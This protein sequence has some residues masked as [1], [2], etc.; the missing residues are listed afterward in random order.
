VDLWARLPWRVLA[1]RR[2]PG[3]SIVDSTVGAAELLRAVT[4]G[5]GRLPPLRD[6]DWRWPLPPD[7]GTAVETL[8]VEEVRR[9]G[10]A[11][12]ETL[13]AARGRVPERALRDALL[14][15]VPI[16][17]S[18]GGREIPVRQ[19]LVQA[20]LRMG[21]DGTGNDDE[22]TVRIAGSWVALAAGTSSVWLQN[23][24][25]LTIRMAK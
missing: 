11:A 13:R 22:M 3:P 14:E 23:A 21:F 10:L 12:A 6:R 9:V 24:P 18:T 17:V 4:E 5:D 20:M 7:D 16:T 8:P 2:V 15:H 19:G 25:S 1:T